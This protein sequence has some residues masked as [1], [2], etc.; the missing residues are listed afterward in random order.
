MSRPAS[1]FPPGYRRET[2][3]F[4]SLEGSSVWVGWSHSLPEPQ[5]SGAMAEVVTFR[6]YQPCL[7]LSPPPTQTLDLLKIGHLQPSSCFH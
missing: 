4:V 3:W 5:E 2:L 7:L 6:Y 1:V